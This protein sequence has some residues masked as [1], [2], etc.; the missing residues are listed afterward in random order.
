MVKVKKTG[1]LA[2][3]ALT[4]MALTG[5]GMAGSVDA[6]AEDYAQNTKTDSS[7]GQETFASTTDHSEGVMSYRDK[8]SGKTYI[9]EDD[10]ATWMSEEAYN[11][12]HPTVNYEWWTYDAYKAWLE[13]EKKTLQEMADEHAEVE[14]SEGTILWTQELTDQ[15]IAEDEQTLEDIRNG[16][17]VSKSVDRDTECMTMFKTDWVGSTAD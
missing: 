13:Q 1:A 11:N 12:S 7:A 17:L 10:G 8:E 14:T 6:F 3:T 9:S 2:L 5:S 4:L 15:Y 16:V